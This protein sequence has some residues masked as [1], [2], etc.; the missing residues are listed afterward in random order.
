MEISNDTIFNLNFFTYKTPFFGSYQGMHYKLECVKVESEETEGEKKEEKFLEVTRWKG[1]FNFA[2]TKEEKKTV[3][4]AF[5]EEG[6]TEAI[7]WLNEE[8]ASRE[9]L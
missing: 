4:F 2:T 3:R 5:S 6:R 9:W 8:L 7:Q 1:P